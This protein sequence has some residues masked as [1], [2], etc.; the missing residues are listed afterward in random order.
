[1]K[2]SGVREENENSRDGFIVRK[3][4]LGFF[5]QFVQVAGRIEIIRRA[6]RFE[7]NCGF[8]HGGG[9]DGSDKQM[10]AS[11][12]AS[13][14]QV[15]MIIGE[16]LFMASFASAAEDGEISSAGQAGVV[17][18]GGGCKQMRFR[19]GAAAAGTFKFGVGESR[20]CGE[21]FLKFRN[22]SCEC[23]FLFAESK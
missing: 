2:G 5:Q 3:Q 20:K 17:H 6:V 4:E 22:G 8:T 1:M 16:I 15:I 12:R 10:T 7:Q 9:R 18:R 13:E 14:F 23:E 11:E 21:R 19:M